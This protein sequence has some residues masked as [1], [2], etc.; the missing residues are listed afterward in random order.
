MNKPHKKDQ[1]YKWYKN[2]KCLIL[3]DAIKI[4][5]NAQYLKIKEKVIGREL[6]YEPEL[7]KVLPT[8]YKT[9][10]SEDAYFTFLKQNKDYI[11]GIF[12]EYEEYNLRIISFFLDSLFKIYGSL[13]DVA[14]EF[15]EEVILFTAL[16]SIEFKRG[17]LKSDESN[18]FNGLENTSYFCGW[19]PFEG[20]TFNSKIISTFV[21]GRHAYNE[22]KILETNLGM[23][24][25][26]D[27]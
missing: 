16:I 18:D 13:K 7:E 3:A 21:N 2:L 27:R 25:E 8:L 19:S 6:N 12:F 1:T 15:Q 22:G 5:D 17:H 24:L 11:Y 4:D 26:F 14:S 9:Y 20:D 10:T 23:Q